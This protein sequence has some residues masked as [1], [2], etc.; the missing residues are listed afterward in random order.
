MTVIQNHLQGFVK[1]IGLGP[2]SPLESQSPGVR[3]KKTVFLKG[4]PVTLMFTWS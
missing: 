4:P 1:T 3:L 2:P